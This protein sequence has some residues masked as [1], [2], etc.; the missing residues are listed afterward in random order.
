[1]VAEGQSD[2]AGGDSGWSAYS[3]SETNLR[4]RILRGKEAR[5]ETNY[6]RVV[7]DVSESCRRG[8]RYP[9]TVILCEG[10]AGEVQRG[11][12][13]SS[14][15]GKHLHRGKIGFFIPNERQSDWDSKMG[16]GK[17]GTGGQW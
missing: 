16:G 3:Q 11:A 2:P 4:E 12:K 5:C 17:V 13:E 14:K 9:R 15:V 8:G 7:K 10:G 1:L 6:A